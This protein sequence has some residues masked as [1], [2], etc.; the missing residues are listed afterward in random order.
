MAKHDEYEE[1]ERVFDPESGV[2]AILNRDTQRARLRFKLA[3]YLW[4]PEEGVYKDA[5][6]VWFSRHHLPGVSR[7]IP[8]VDE[9]VL[10]NL[11]TLFSK[12]KGNDGKNRNRR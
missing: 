12:E 7:I 9:A 1:V 6:T 2:V 3:R 4:I 5:S 8:R 11:D 10:N